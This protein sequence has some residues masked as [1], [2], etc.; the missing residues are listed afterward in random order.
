MNKYLLLLIASL[1]LYS[2]GNNQIDVDNEVTVPVSVEE[3]KLKPIEE[4]VDAT[5]T[6]YAS[7]QVTLTA[8][9]SGKYSLQ[10]NPA[11]GK[12]YKLGDQ[13]KAGSVIIRLEDKEYENNIRIDYQKLQLEQ[14]KSQYEKQKSLYDKG[15]VTQQELKT[16]ELDYINQE[17]TYEQAELQLAKMNV[18]APFAGVIVDLP[19]YTPDVKVQQNAQLVKIMNYSSLYLE[20]NLPEK[21]MGIVKTGQPARIMNYSL[22]DDTLSGKVTQISPAIE[23]SSR[24]FK[25][26]LAINNP[27]LSL[28]PGMFVKAE[29]TVAKKDSAIVIPKNIILS[30]QRGKTIFIVEK[31]ASQERL[32]STGLENPEFVEVTKGLK[33]NDR[34][35]TKGFETLRSR[36]KVKII[37]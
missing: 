19:Y 23:A 32:I 15:G 34:I 16:A 24:T 36:Q 18:T 33:V 28:R 4:F 22:V 3:I 31:G 37:K 12:Q 8:E 1:F 21:Q 2:C 30:R 27:D 10:T 17:Y 11:T 5:G 9:F 7:K 6:V 20:V 14:K 35:V 29:L 13:V 26:M 25:T